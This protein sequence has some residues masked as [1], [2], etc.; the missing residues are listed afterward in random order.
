MAEMK[1][2]REEKRTPLRDVIPLDT[3]YNI[4]IEVSSLCNARCVYCAHSRKDHGVYEGNMSMEL[5]ARVIEEIKKFPKK[6][7][8]IET[9]SFGEPLCNPHLDEMIAIIRKEDIAEK[10]NFTTNG[11]LLTP[12]RIDALMAAGVDTIRISLQGLNAEMYDKMCGVKVNFQ[13]FLNNLRYLYEHR[14][15]CKI[16]MKI[17]DVALR[18]IP[19]GEKKFEAMFGDKAD[20]LFVEHIL[21]IYQDVDYGSLDQMILDNSM[22]G[23]GNVAQHEV[24]KVCHRPFYRLRVTA[25][26]EVMANCCDQPH[27]IRYGNIMEEGL[28]ELW[29]GKVRTSFLKMQ[30]Q[31]K[32]FQHP[33]CRDCVLANDITNEADLLDPW[34]EEI[35]CR[36]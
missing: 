10:I 4:G 2:W 3:P 18:D 8:L 21:P 6:I 35:L 12:K 5:F 26:G 15:G 1:Y 28:V 24:H 11:L 9:Y 30:L 19:D 14:S 33:V 7:R 23:R 27:D 29:N 32:R 16:R 17:A 31:G 34:A 20:S 13:E 25:N 22:N 36:F